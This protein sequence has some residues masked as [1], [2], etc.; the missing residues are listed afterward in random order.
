MGSATS[1]PT[2]PTCK[3]YLA[4]CFHPAEA[5]TPQ[6][7]PSSEDGGGGALVPTAPVASPEP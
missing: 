4:P 7:L 2:G 1:M 3:A 6:P 5:E